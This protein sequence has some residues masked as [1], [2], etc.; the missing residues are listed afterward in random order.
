MADADYGVTVTMDRGAAE[1]RSVTQSGAALTIG[2]EH[3]AD[4]ANEAIEVTVSLPRLQRLRL[5]AAAN[6]SLTGFDQ[7]HL[8][9][10][11]SGIAYLA[12]H[13]LRTGHPILTTGGVA[14]VDLSTRHPLRSHDGGN[15]IRVDADDL[16]YT[17]ATATA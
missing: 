13:D 11:T 6:V 17:S 2:V 10:S 5:S 4:D 3:L 9:A 16:D 7:Q 8:E 15:P 12:G 1:R 14:Y